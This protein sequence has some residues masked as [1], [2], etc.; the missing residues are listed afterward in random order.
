MNPKKKNK[1]I[2]KI[3]KNKKKMTR[4]ILNSFSKEKNEPQT[5]RCAII[6]VPITPPLPSG[7]L[8]R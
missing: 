3:M 7:E 4:E 8:P 6:G 2:Y 5:I 1:K